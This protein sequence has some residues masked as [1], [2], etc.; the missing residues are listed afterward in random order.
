MDLDF[1]LRLL[2]IAVN[3]QKTTTRTPEEEGYGNVSRYR[4][5]YLLQCALGTR[6]N[7]RV[8]ET[9]SGGRAV[10]FMIMRQNLS[11]CRS[12]GIFVIIIKF[13]YETKLRGRR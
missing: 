2:G 10:N 4:G 3:T 6:N 8:N 9:E 1:V 11:I 13:C 7:W 5:F 12:D